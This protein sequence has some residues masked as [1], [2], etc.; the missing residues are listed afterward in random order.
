[1]AT[2]AFPVYVGWDA[3]ED[4]AYQVC[5]YSMLRRSSIPLHIEPLR[6]KSL[7]Y[8]GLYYRKTKQ[9]ADGRMVDSVDGKP[10]STEFAFTR[11]LVP[12]LQR[13]EGWA[14]FC[15]C[16]FLFL[17]DIVDLTKLC[18]PDKAVMVV[19]HE[20][21][22]T[23]TIKMDGQVQ[24]AYPRKNWSSLV[25]W[26]CGHVANKSLTPALVSNYAGAFLH[27]FMWLADDQIGEIPYQWNYLEGHYKSHD[28]KAVHY[29]RGGPWF[30]NYSDVEYADAWYR[31]KLLMEHERDH[32][33]TRGYRHG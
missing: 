11:F 23:E 8:A 4:V 6:D 33:P 19:K 15:D 26:N 10:F 27:R 12:V 25:L 7:R 30:D 22:P 18:D 13:Y 2:N 9:D 31:E 20:Y 21:A 14:L 32:T 24:E 5:K 29:T 17:A 1:M 28:A 3:R 16:D